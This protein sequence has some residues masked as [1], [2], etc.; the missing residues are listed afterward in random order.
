[1]T[2]DSGAVDVKDDADAVVEWLKTRGPGRMVVRVHD[3]DM[4][5][6]GT[7]LFVDIGSVTEIQD[8]VNEVLAQAKAQ[9]EEKEG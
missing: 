4:L 2:A 6:V 5:R 7:Q 8:A 1:M 9:T 3:H